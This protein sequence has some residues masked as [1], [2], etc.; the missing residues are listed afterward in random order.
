M[1]RIARASAADFCHHL[2]NRG[3]DHAEGFHESDDYDA[4]VDLIVAAGPG[5]RSGS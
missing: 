3:D 1:P 4:F 2:L 5:C